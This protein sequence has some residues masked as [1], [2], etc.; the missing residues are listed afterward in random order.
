MSSPD[1]VCD[2][3]VEIMGVGACKDVVISAVT[4]VLV[5]PSNEEFTS[6]HAVVDVC[7][8]IVHLLLL[9]R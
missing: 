6:M 7:L 9:M 3:D 2:G 4:C 1:H 5:E 8:M